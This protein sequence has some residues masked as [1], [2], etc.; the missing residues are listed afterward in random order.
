MV[1]GAGE[2]FVCW[3]TWRKVGNVEGKG[4]VEGGGGGRGKGRL[5]GG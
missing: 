2:G 5:I 3:M 1:S 4:K